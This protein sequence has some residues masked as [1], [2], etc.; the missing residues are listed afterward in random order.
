MSELVKNKT[1]ALSTNSYVEEL[2]SYALYLISVKSTTRDTVRSYLKNVVNLLSHGQLDVNSFWWDDLKPKHFELI[3]EILRKDKR[4]TT[5]NTYLAAMRGVATKSFQNERM[6]AKTYGLIKLVKRVKGNTLTSQQDAISIDIVHKVIDKALHKDKGLALRD[7]VLFS[8]LFGCGLR[9]HELS[10]LE[11]SCW[12]KHAKEIVVTG[13]GDKVRRVPVPN[14]VSDVLQTWQ[15]EIRGYD[16]GPLLCRFEKNDKALL[17]KSLSPSGIR[18][19]VTTWCSEFEKEVG[20]KVSPHDFRRAYATYLLDE[21]ADIN[22]VSKLMGHAD[23]KT[24]AI[25]DRR[26]E[27]AKKEAVDKYFD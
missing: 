24:T 7:A 11:L 10:T 5:I 3:K 16:V 22:I 26:D 21:G 12:D 17:T 14:R 6:D 20:R 1:K 13:K 4:P 23:I 8:L 15:D 2:S 19:V 9:R 25:Y 18:Y 27:Q